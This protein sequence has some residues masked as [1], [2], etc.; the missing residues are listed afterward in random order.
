MR[1]LRIP[2]PYSTIIILLIIIIV[3]FIATLFTVNKL[4]NELAHYVEERSFF[5]VAANLEPKRRN[6]LE[7]ARRA[8]HQFMQPPFFWPPPAV[9]IVRIDL[10]YPCHSNDSEFDGF[11]VEVVQVWYYFEPTYV[12]LTCDSVTWGKAP[13]VK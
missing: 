7:S 11:M 3:G 6:G 2:K 10:S 9:K 4:G 8:I 12:H 13:I 1:F 5:E